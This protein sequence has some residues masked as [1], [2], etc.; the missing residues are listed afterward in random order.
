M[1]SDIDEDTLYKRYRQVLSDHAQRETAINDSFPR[2][3]TWQSVVLIG[4]A[5]ES[6]CCRMVNA[7]LH[8]RTILPHAFCSASIGTF[9]STDA[10]FTSVT[11]YDESQSLILTK[12]T[13]I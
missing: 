7:H 3:Q 12:N 9:L 6:V 5:F 13:D 4:R 8:A 1:P 10:S 11:H 2:S